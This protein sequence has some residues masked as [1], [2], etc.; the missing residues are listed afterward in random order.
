MPSAFDSTVKCVL[1]IRFSYRLATEQRRVAT[2]TGYGH[3]QRY[4]RMLSRFVLG[5]QPL[6][7][8]PVSRFACNV[9]CGFR[10]W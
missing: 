4:A 7:N 9:G 8:V 2:T 3:Q 6:Q 5:E 10:R 1:H